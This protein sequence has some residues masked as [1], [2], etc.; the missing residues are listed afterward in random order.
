MCVCVCVCQHRYSDLKVQVDALVGQYQET[1]RALQQLSQANTQLAH[2]MKELLTAL[3]TRQPGP[4][5]SQQPGSAGV[6]G[7]AQL[8]WVA[9]S[10]GVAAGVAAVA[11]VML[12]S[13][14]S[15]QRS[16]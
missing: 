14:A 7:W 8:P 1:H 3:A 12:S 11:V 6:G 9:M 10:A 4:A 13:R 2:N 15:T 16:S 5:Q